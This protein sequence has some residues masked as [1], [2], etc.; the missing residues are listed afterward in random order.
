MNARNIPQ[1]RRILALCAMFFA[2]GAVACGGSADHPGEFQA[3]PSGD[4]T[5]VDEEV[6]EEPE[7]TDAGVPNAKCMEGTTQE[8]KITLK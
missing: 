4:D 6:P 3:D 7:A 1:P 5:N 2:L 8:C